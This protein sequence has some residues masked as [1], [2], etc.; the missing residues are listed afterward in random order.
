M[1]LILSLLLGSLSLA[2]SA[3]KIDSVAL[4][5]GVV[6]HY[7]SPAT[8]EKARKVLLKELTGTAP[9][10]F[11][12]GTLIVGPALWARYKDVPLLQ[13]IPGS[14]LTIRF[15]NQQLAG[16]VTQ[17]KEDFDKVWSQLRAEVKGEKITLRKATTPELQYYWAVISFDIDEPL[18]IAET[19]AHRYLLNLTPKDLKLVWLDEV[20]AGM[21]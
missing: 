11:N 8:L 7:C 5:R 17:S 4:P 18:F 12:A 19:S 10:D 1:K 3:Q 15:D 14:D 16:K 21:K 6:Y 2:A 13:G 9:V 20:P